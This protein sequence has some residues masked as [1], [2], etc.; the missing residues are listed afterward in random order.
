MRVTI[1]QPYLVPYAG[2]YR[3]FE[4]DVFVIYD[5]AQF[6]K[7]GWVNRNI[8]TKHDGTAGWLTLPIAKLPLDT[9]IKDI[10]FADDVGEK[11]GKQLRKF[12]VFKHP[13]K[14]LARTVSLATGF[15][16]PMTAIVSLLEITRKQLGFQCEII[17]SSTLKIKPSIKGQERVIAICEALKATE[18][19]N[20]PGGVNLYRKEAFDKRGVE[21]KFLKSYQGNA[22]SMLERLIFEKAEDVR[23]EID[24]NAQFIS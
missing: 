12:K 3:L 17:R 1:N 23:R 22:M 9:R 2:Y 14:H 6:P 13:M 7:E 15:P 4:T 11:W 5:D 21:L 20:A 8:L 10:E 18:Y 19:V 16:S 24:S